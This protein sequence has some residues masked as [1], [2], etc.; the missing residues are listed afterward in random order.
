MI[1][2]VMLG[3]GTSTGVPVVGCDCAVCSSPDERNRRSRASLWMRWTDGETERSV[4]V[5]T[6]PDFRSQALREGISRLDAVLFTHAHADHIFGLDDVR[7]FNFRQRAPLACFGTR[8]TL[9]HVRSTFGY[10][11]D[12]PTPG[13]GVPQLDLRPV[14]ERFEL[15]GETVTPV[16][17][18]HGEREVLGFRLRDFAYVT[19]VS[20]IPQGSRDLLRGLDVLILGALRYRSHPTHFSIP[21]ALE[22]IAELDPRRTYFTHLAHDVDAGDL[23]VELPEGVA[24]GYD[25]LRFEI[26]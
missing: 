12:G 8:S 3:S 19:D 11:F 10:A 21:E 15:F 14:R 6:G 24:L 25:G 9:D 2:V 16:P 17:V 20:A 22:C 23:Q 4:V 26:A 5:D 13:G 1:E 7:P 18:L